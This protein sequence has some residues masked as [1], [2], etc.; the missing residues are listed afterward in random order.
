MNDGNYSSGARRLA[1]AALLLAPLLLGLALR[2][3]G[4]RHGE[5]D[6]VY[7]PDVAKQTVVARSVYHGSS[8]IRRIYKDDISRALYPYGTAYILGKTLRRYSHLTGD[9]GLDDVHRWCWALRM[10]YVSVTL[11]VAAVGICMCVLTRRIGIV[12]T[13]LL[14]T[15]LLV[16]PVNAYFSHYGMNDVPLLAMLLLTWLFAGLM[17]DERRIPCWSLTAGLAV[18]LGFGIKYQA[19]LGLVFPGIAWLF[20][21]RSK[22][23]KW[24]VASAVA[25][26]AGCVA[27]ALMTAPL[28]RREP[29][30]FFAKLPEFMEWQANIMGEHTPLGQKLPRNIPAFLRTACANGG[31]M[32]GIS[33]F[34]AIAAH[35]RRADRDIRTTIRGLSAALFCVLLAVAIVAS[36][37]II[38]PNDIMP[39]TA[40]AIVVACLGL[41][42]ALRTRDRGPMH[43]FPVAAMA[44]GVAAWFLAASLQ[45]SLALARPDTR[46]LA[47]QWCRENLETPSAALRERYTLS[48]DKEGVKDVRFRYLGEPKARARLD[49]GRFDYV[50][51][52][53]LAHDRFFDRFSP[54]HDEEAQAAYTKM[55][56]ELAPI[57]T[58][59]DREMP[60]A[61]PYITIYARKEPE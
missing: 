10:R 58:F 55:R 60:Y 51:T 46:L 11:I 16:E 18:G 3:V 43:Y 28:L 15:L 49:A 17:P 27:G 57:A 13:A 1:A 31:W 50:I 12:A 25:I 5:P 40:F 21:L 29:A 8:S 22:G 38:R 48:A 33:A 2:L 54:Y 32:L 14:G 42:E 9:D 36:R 34:V 6:M 61:Q 44:A 52:S 19:V 23:W 24:A 56:D 7:H 20:M 4:I 47:R 53:S 30:Y 35:A 41:S 39:V 45:D 37:D 59:H 26:V